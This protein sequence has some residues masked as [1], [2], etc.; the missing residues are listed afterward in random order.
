[1]GQLNDQNKWMVMEAIVQKWGEIIWSMGSG[2]L[3]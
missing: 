1:M 3:I 2:M